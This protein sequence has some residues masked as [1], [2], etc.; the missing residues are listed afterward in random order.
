MANRQTVLGENGAALLGDSIK[1]LRQLRDEGHNAD[2]GLF[3]QARKFRRV[4]LFALAVWEV[5]ADLELSV[6][7]SVEDKLFAKLHPG[8]LFGDSW[9]LALSPL[10]LHRANIKLDRA[11]AGINVSPATARSPSGWNAA[12][13]RPSPS[14][15]GRMRRS[16]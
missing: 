1:P 7:A 6:A 16:R 13:A 11:V 8:G 15:W 4:G 2:K 12:T 14:A 5:H 10:P 9:L 3:Y